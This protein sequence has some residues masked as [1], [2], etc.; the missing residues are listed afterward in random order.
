MDM[1]SDT[2]AWAFVAWL[3]TSTLIT[4]VT[5]RLATTRVEAPGWV[6]AINGALCLFP[7]LSLVVLAYLATLDNRW[8]H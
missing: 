1:Q 4:I 8:P 5:W 6:T 3:V 7:P 2:F